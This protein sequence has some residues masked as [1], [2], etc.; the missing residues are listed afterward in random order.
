VVFTRLACIYWPNRYFLFDGHQTRMSTTN[1]LDERIDNLGLKTEPIF[2]AVFGHAWP[3]L[4][5]VLQKHYANRP[6]TDDVTIVHGTLDV[7][8]AGPI[9]I[10]AWLFWLMR[11]IPP[12][13]ETDVPVDVYFESDRHS[14]CFHF[15]RIFNFKTRQAYHFKSRMLPIKDNEVIE[16]MPFGLGWRLNYVW[17]DECVK[18]KHKGYV[19]HAFGHFIALPLT[20]LIGQGNAEEVMV[21]D[22]RFNMN[23][24]I[25]HPWWGK[26]YEY[27]GQFTTKDSL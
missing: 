8:C 16:I 24:T 21:D 7:M 25:T 9:K 22:H 14:K 12:C 17:E 4:P 6:Y 13:N 5:L 15:T 20:F 2:K 11:G 23:M 10:F 1:N 19:L 27:K 26:I 18:L 3:N